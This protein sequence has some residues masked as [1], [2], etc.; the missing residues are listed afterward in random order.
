MKLIEHILLVIIGR[1]AKNDIRISNFH[2]PYTIYISQYVRYDI[3]TKV[4]Y[5]IAY[6]Q[7]NR[8]LVN[9]LFQISYTVYTDYCYFSRLYVADDGQSVC[10]LH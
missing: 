4:T 5:N 10:Y 8:G 6:I 2:L 9:E 7:F 3:K 1:N